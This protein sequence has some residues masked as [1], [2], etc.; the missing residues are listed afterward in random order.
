MTW[1]ES[2]KYAE[3]NGGSLYSLDEMRK[4]LAYRASKSYYDFDF[5]KGRQ[6]DDYVPLVDSD[7]W[8]AIVG[9]DEKNKPHRDWVQIGKSHHHLGKSHRLECDGYPV[10]GDDKS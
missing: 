5:F 9:F 3:Q 1:T 10:W 6:Y 2:N 4:I 7:A 8:I